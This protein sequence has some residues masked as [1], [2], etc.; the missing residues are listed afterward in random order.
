MVKHKRN[1]Y[2]NVRRPRRELGS[3]KTMAIVLAAVLS[4]LAIGLTAY[5]A[6]VPAN[7]QGGAKTSTAPTSVTPGP[8]AS[9]SA[10]AKATATPANGVMHVKEL[11]VKFTLPAS[12]HDLEYTTARL[13]GD[14]QTTSVGFGTKTLD[15]LGCPYAD[16]PLGYLT[17]DVD[18]GGDYVG[19]ANSPL[20]YI[21]STSR[22][23]GDEVNSETA[24]LKTALRSVSSDN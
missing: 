18:R 3:V 8:S 24:A 9:T 12:L 1:R 11:K 15:A 17:E 16:A 14:T 10:G 22:C 13:P 23:S 6:I 2:S 5:G 20:Y 7:P 19:S 4:V 21:S